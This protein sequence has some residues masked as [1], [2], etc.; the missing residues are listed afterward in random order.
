MARTGMVASLGRVGTL[1]VALVPTFH[2]VPGALPSPCSEGG[3]GR[4]W[5]GMGEFSNMLARTLCLV[6]LA[7][8][9]AAFSGNSNPTG[10]FSWRVLSRHKWQACCGAGARAGAGMR[11]GG[12]LPCVASSLRLRWIRAVLAAAPRTLNT[13]PTCP[14]LP[15]PP[16]GWA[17]CHW[18]GWSG[19]K[20]WAGVLVGVRH[21]AAAVAVLCHV[22]LHL[23]AH[24]G[25]RDARCAFLPAHRPAHLAEGAHVRGAGDLRAAA[26]ARPRRWRPSPTCTLRPPPPC[27]PPHPCPMPLTGNAVQSAQGLVGR[28]LP[29]HSSS[30]NFN[31]IVGAPHVVVGWRGV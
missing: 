20:P 17:K 9:A 2:T 3:G 25:A 16:S 6:G 12:P 29:S 7:A 24:A 21:A 28:L 10:A 11:T 23:A 18:Q 19:R 15:L 1:M 13:E 4:G 22:E 26:G 14:T 27:V 30:F 31:L 5:R 8:S